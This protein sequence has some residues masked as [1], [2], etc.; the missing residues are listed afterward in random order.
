MSNLYNNNI[1]IATE[2]HYVYD[3]SKNRINQS[4]INNANQILN[5]QPIDDPLLN[6]QQ[7]DDPLLNNQPIDH[8]LL[9]NQSTIPNN[10]LN[11]FSMD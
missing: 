9:H 10:L 1:P 5:N 8:P 2:V 4:N 3:S 6:N 7:I 11:P